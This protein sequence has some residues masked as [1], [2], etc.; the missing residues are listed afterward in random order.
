MK[1]TVTVP[2]LS[3]GTQRVKAIPKPLGPRQA[4]GYARPT[5]FPLW[6]KSPGPAEGVGRLHANGELA[7]AAGTHVSESAIAPK[8]PL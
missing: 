4:R 6:L 5:G 3:L 1:T 7:P 2:P 8:R